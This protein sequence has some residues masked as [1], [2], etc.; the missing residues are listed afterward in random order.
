MGTLRVVDT[1]RQDYLLEVVLQVL[2]KG[3]A[4]SVA[5]IT[6]HAGAE[7]EETEIA[8][9][10]DALVARGRLTK[11]PIATENYYYPVE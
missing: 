11:M 6:S 10:L 7:A 9:A 8:D 5:N 1:S 4:G 3:L 2:S